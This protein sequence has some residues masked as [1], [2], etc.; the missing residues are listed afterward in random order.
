MKLKFK[1]YSGKPDKQRIINAIKGEPVDRVPNL[2]ALIEDKIV[3]MILGRNIGGATL[4]NMTDRVITK[5]PLD[6]AQKVH[7]NLEIGKEG[8]PIYAKD[9]IE[10]CEII[11]QDVIRIA[12]FYAPFSKIDEDGKK[13]MVFDRSFKNR[14]DV[15][16][17]LILPTENMDYFKWMLP[18]LKEYKEEAA[19]KNIAVLVSGGDLFQQLYEFIFGI[20]NF[21]LLLYDD[22]S[23]IEEL[24]ESGVE[25]WTGFTKYMVNEG[26][27]LISF[28]DDLAFKSGLF[29]K[30]DI[31]KKLYLKRYKRVIEPAANAGLPVWFHSDGKIYEI[32]EDLIKM[33]VN[34]INPMEPY[35]MDYKYL[36]KNYGKSL[37]LMGNID[38]TFPLTM[39]TPE[40][41]RRDVK[42]HMEILKPGYRYICAS[43]HD[44]PNCIPGENIVAFFDA[45]HEYG[46]Y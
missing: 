46:L 23:L 40:D 1:P 4:G 20:E 38:I 42:E 12:D 8:R 44:L 33:G 22:Y 2:E 14:K 7:E 45:I 21:S 36:K 26:I 27:D 3:E 39:G 43:S 32:L 34:C 28:S 11:G 24:I 35:S 30:Y 13:V 29:V 17:K 9:F 6:K 19:K 37:T 31:F 5:N 18:Y 10:L 16:E 25:Y 15:R 41:I